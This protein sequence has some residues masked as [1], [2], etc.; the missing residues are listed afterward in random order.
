MEI[1]N[2]SITGNLVSL[3][4]LLQDN[5]FSIPNYQRGYSWG[6][7]QLEDLK[8]DIEHLQGKDRK[9]YTGTIVMTPSEDKDGRYDIVDGQQR[10]T[11]LIILLGVL[12][13]KLQDNS[14]REL[15][16]ERGSIGNEVPVLIPNNE[17]AK[18]FKETIIEDKWSKE[19][20]V[21]S[22]A[23]IWDAK[24]FFNEWFN[25][26]DED[27]LREISSIVQQQLGFLIFTPE[28]TDEIG[29]MFEVINNRG[30]PLSQLEKMKNFF[31]YYASVMGMSKLERKVNENWEYILQSLSRANVT[32][33]F[34]ESTFLKYAYIVYY[35][36]H[37]SQSSYVYDSLKE[38]YLVDPNKDQ[39]KVAKEYEEIVG[40]I[41]FLWSAAKYYSFFKRKDH[42]RRSNIYTQKLGEIL[43]RLRTQSST[44]SILP[45]YFALLHHVEDHRNN[46][47]KLLDLV[48]KM[49]FRMYVLPNNRRSDSGQ[50]ELYSFAYK[51]YNW[52]EADE[53]E[54]GDK[55]KWLEGKIKGITK[56]FS[57]TENFI[58][59]LTLDE[60]DDFDFYKWQGLRY[61]LANYERYLRKGQEDW[62]L[63]KLFVSYDTRSEYSDMYLSREHLFS[64]KF[65]HKGKIPEDQREK[66]RLGNFV[67]LGAGTNVKQSNDP[68]T[69]KIETIANRDEEH[70]N[71]IGFSLLQVKE[72]VPYKEEIYHAVTKHW[73]KKTENTYIEQAQYLNDQRETKLIKFALERWAMPGE[74]TSIFIE[75]SSPKNEKNVHKYVLQGAGRGVIN[76]QQEAAL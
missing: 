21:N 52:S 38:K 20:E 53:E 30:K 32:D 65:T 31:I 29:V 47:R 12:S 54:N 64:T 23:R 1:T 24:S 27:Q 11:T 62:E 4:D 66:R 60:D 70:K 35:S 8:E 76:H 49:N 9:H 72:L 28:Q 51:F 16:L 19:F 37:K 33:N 26:L 57:N 48:E 39:S 45:L 25:K 50:G 36:P 63:E 44:A 17:T 42:F 61:F 15:S 5:Y 67:L 6:K 40:F 56:A 7:A 22:H 10:L 18:Y 41:D 3:K 34:E 71:S 13:D 55:F 73:G 75:V 74:D 58:R 2:K 59:S 14:L 68:V 43:S 69:K 46:V